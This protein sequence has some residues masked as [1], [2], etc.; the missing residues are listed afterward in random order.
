[1]SRIEDKPAGSGPCAKQTVTA[2]LVTPDGSQYVGTN[3][4]WTP[5]EVCPRGDLP[6]GVGYEMCK[7][8]C[9]QPAH[10]EVNA[11]NLARRNHIWGAR[12]STIYLE[13]HTAPCSNCQIK[14]NLFDVKE[15][16]VA[17]PPNVLER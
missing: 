2:T 10:A 7:D 14:A 13:G 9:H 17:S 5:Q 4:C 6:S 11:I 15:I 3:Y 16:I 8:I 12:G 1:M